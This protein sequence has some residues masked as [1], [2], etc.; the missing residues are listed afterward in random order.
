MS[1]KELSDAEKRARTIENESGAEEYS[2]KMYDEDAPVSSEFDEPHKVSS[3]GADLR[4]AD[5]E[6]EKK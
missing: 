4:K 1:N 6:E 2:Q 5:T 3:T